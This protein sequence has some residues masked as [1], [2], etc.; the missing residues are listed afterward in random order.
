MSY[1]SQ[2]AIYIYKTSNDKL[3]L[4]TAPMKAKK[5][6]RSRT[7]Y[8]SEQLMALER[9]FSKSRYLSR[10]R[11]IEIA[12]ILHLNERQVKVWFQNRRMK[13][14]KEEQGECTKS[15]GSVEN[16]KSTSTQS[17]E[18]AYQTVTNISPTYIQNLPPPPPPYPYPSNY[19]N[20][21]LLNNIAE[22]QYYDNIQNTV[23]DCYT[24]T[25]L[26][27]SNF[28]QDTFQANQIYQQQP[29]DQQHSIYSNQ[30]QTDCLYQ[31]QANYTNQQQGS[32][33]YQLGENCTVPYISDLSETC[34]NQ[35][36]NNVNN[37]D[38][39]T[40][41]NKTSHELTQSNSYDN[42]ITSLFSDVIF[43]DNENMTDILQL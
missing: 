5:G 6:K 10:S 38:S 16:L 12:K 21:V 43:L 40:T 23:K 9:A 30:H 24:N 25:T 29:K 34:Q 17:T 42:L 4:F 36:N 35:N 3:Q 27:S 8:N 20:G 14:K 33:L 1:L 31:Q 7:A 37:N 39:E 2:I 32:C 28:L 41:N 18:T 26:S 19:S 22:E 13:Y 11:R 15:F